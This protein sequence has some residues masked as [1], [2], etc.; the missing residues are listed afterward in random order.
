MANDKNEKGWFPKEAAETYD[1]MIKIYGALNRNQFTPEDREKISNTLESFNNNNGLIYNAECIGILDDTQQDKLA[2]V[3]KQHL[4]NDNVILEDKS[5]IPYFENNEAIIS[6]GHKHHSIVVKYWRQGFDEKNNPVSDDEQPHIYRYYRTE[7]NAGDGTKKKIG[8]LAM[9]I[10]T[11]EILPYTF[12]GDNPVGVYQG[13]RYDENYYKVMKNTI[14]NLIIADKV[15][16]AS[17]KPEKAYIYRVKEEEAIKDPT[18]IVGNIDFSKIIAENKHKPDELESI[19][20]WVKYRNIRRQ[21]KG[22]YVTKLS[23]FGALQQSGNCTYKSIYNFVKDKAGYLLSYDIREMIE[24]HPNAQALYETINKKIDE[25]QLESENLKKSIK[26]DKKFTKGQKLGEI[27]NAEYFQNKKATNKPQAVYITTGSDNKSNQTTTDISQGVLRKLK[28]ELEGFKIDQKSKIFLNKA[29]EFIESIEPYDENIGNVKYYDML[30]KTS[31]KLVEYLCFGQITPLEFINELRE[32]LNAVEE[33]LDDHEHKKTKAKFNQYLTST[34]RDYE[35]FVKEMKKADEADTNKYHN[36]KMKSKAEQTIKYFM[37]S[38][39]DTNDLNRL[40]NK[41]VES[42]DDLQ[43]QQTSKEFIDMLMIYTY[44]SYDTNLSLMGLL[45]S[46]VGGQQNSLEGVISHDAPMETR[47]QAFEIILYIKEE[48]IKNQIKLNPLLSYKEAEQKFNKFKVNDKTIEDRWNNYVP[49]LRELLLNNIKKYV[50]SGNAEDEKF[51]NKLKAN[52]QVFAQLDLLSLQANL[53]ST[54]EEQRASKIIQEQKCVISERKIKVIL[55]EFAKLNSLSLSD[56]Q[57]LHNNI[58][59]TINNAEDEV[60]RK[61]LLDNIITYQYDGLSLIGQLFF[62]TSKKN[63]EENIRSQALQTILYLK[64]KFVENQ[65]KLDNLS[66]QQAEQKFYDLKV[67]GKTIDSRKVK[68]ATNIKP[69]IDPKNPP[70]EAVKPVEVPKKE[71]NPVVALIP[72]P[73]IAPP[74]SPKE[75]IQI[76][77]DEVEKIIYRSSSKLL[78]LLKQDGGETSFD[79]EIN[80]LASKINNQENKEFLMSVAGRAKD[81][82]RKINK[83][84]TK[85]NKNIKNKAVGAFIG[86]A[87]LLLACTIIVANA[88]NIKAM[89][90]LFGEQPP[91]GKKLA[92]SILSFLTSA[93]GVGIYT[94]KG[95]NPNIA[96]NI[97]DEE[98]GKF[99]SKVYFK[100]IIEKTKKEKGF[101]GRS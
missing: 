100:N 34:Q 58:T 36:D 31:I 99:N 25:L 23:K 48:F 97:Q 71:L 80:S 55:N 86:A 73:P 33:N 51:V 83:E 45:F 65:T 46:R 8:N 43:G 59:Q 11:T 7:Y 29:I 61:H 30:Q 53:I 5:S 94:F 12:K 27:I 96:T 15:M 49:E 42:C 38:R 93:A 75:P 10:S 47:I 16:S 82:A 88:V 54:S 50:E 21:L 56:F 84:D 69:I 6:G 1:L 52:K 64:D 66:Y 13:Y 19:E 17:I 32:K 40:Y 14:E 60:I 67:N 24:Q 9:T 72:T 89:N 91:I 68:Y 90:N 41:I 35:S 37:G 44:K 2:E 77:D 62:S 76:P 95:N 63:S 26:Q 81:A 39:A 3:S 85:V 4:D 98:L 22:K 101:V 28:T 57:K 20:S 87:G 92:F 70:V 74:V 78:K 79:T 18:K